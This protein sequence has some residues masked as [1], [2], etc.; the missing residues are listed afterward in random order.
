[1]LACNSGVW[2]QKEKPREQ[3]Q[4]L[5]D[6]GLYERAMPILLQYTQE[7]PKDWDAKY[8]IGACFFKLGQAP[9]EI[10]RASCRER[11]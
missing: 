9:R 11:V 4:R 6:N 2:A 8:M 1:M 7:K 3:A 10:G 5:F